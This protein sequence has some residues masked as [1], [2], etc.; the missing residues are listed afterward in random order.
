[1][2]EDLNIEKNHIRLIRLALS[3]SETQ[4]SA[5]KRLGI[6]PAT[7]TNKIKQYGL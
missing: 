1:M 4:R 5:A 7:L 6:T 2:T 3:L